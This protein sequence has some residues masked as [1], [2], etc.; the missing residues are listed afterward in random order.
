MFAF[1]AV[2]VGPCTLPPVLT[3][4]S[5]VRRSILL[6]CHTCEFHRHDCTA[7]VLDHHRVLFVCGSGVCE[8]AGAFDQLGGLIGELGDRVS[9]CLG[10]SS[11]LK[12][13]LLSS[14]LF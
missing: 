12:G 3:R 6:D 14:F 5:H 7:D 4:L 10:G 1:L 11:N 9:C 8:Q 2:W 13:P